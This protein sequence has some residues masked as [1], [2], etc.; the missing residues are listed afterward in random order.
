MRKIR[1]FR[2][3]LKA[4][5]VARVA[6]KSG[7]PVQSIATLEAAIAEASAGMAPAVLFETFPRAEAAEATLSPLPGLAFSLVLA[8]LGEGPAAKRRALAAA[9]P[10]RLPLWSVVC[11]CALDSA[12]RFATA[13]LEG[14]AAQENCDLSPL[15]PLSGADALGPALARLE[16]GKIGVS[17][18]GERLKPE[19][20]CLVSVSWVVRA[21]SRKSGKS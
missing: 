10:D 11:R 2:L 6:R 8:T 16:A 7:L 14:E 4:R 12:L 13:L 15:S 18:D 21:R 3:N 20:S 17:R 19:D 1:G 9:C 5:E